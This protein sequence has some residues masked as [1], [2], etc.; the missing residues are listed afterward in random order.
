MQTVDYSFRLAIAT[1]VVLCAYTLAYFTG[2][3]PP[4]LFAAAILLI[5]ISAPP[6]FIFHPLNVLTGYYFL[7]YC[8]ALMFGEKWQMYFTFTSEVERITS[9]MNC[10]TFLI[11]Y[12]ILYLTTKDC[13]DENRKYDVSG[14]KIRQ[15]LFI[16]MVHIIISFLLLCLII[17]LS[18]FPLS[19]WL[20]SPG[21]AYQD[22]S[23]TGYAIILAFFLSGYILTYGGYMIYSLPT[24][25]EKRIVL[26]YYLIAAFFLYIPVLSR[27]RLLFFTVFLSMPSIFYLRLKIKTVLIFIGIFLGSVLLSSILRNAINDE[28][29][30]FEFLWKY[31][32]VYYW[33]TIVVEYEPVQWFHTSFIGFRKLLIGSGYSA[34]YG[35]TISQLFTE[36]YVRGMFEHSLGERTTIQFPV[37][38]DMYINAYYIFATPFLAFFFW[39]VGRS[40]RVAFLT[41]NL[42][43]MFVASYLILAI[44]PGGLRGMLLD[45]TLLQ[46]SFV[47]IG[48]YFLLKNYYVCYHRTNEHYSEEQ[49]DNM[50]LSNSDQA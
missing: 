14:K 19:V 15:D 32:D 26:L 37:E 43:W 22:R 3:M 16:P 39:I 38:V 12:N 20:T 2:Y 29:S 47:C 24:L 21:T 49:K 11:G 7:F 36:K 17:A 6:R 33:T 44:L 30:F 5:Y 9:C 34:D 23:G 40:Y 45:Y 8:L 4:I 27:P 10:A 48:S 31:C 46:N 13:T 25:K 50:L 42:G 18:H 41:S 1:F 35:Y 28:S